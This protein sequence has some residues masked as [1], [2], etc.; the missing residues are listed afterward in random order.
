[1]VEPQVQQRPRCHVDDEHQR[2]VHVMDGHHRKRAE[3]HRHQLD[4]HHRPARREPHGQELVVDVRL[5][6]HEQ[7]LLVARPAHHH[8][9]HVQ[10]RHQQHAE[11]NQYRT[12]LHHQQHIRRVHTIFY[13]EKAQ[14]ESQRQAARVAH[15]NLAPHV[16]ISEHVVRE[17]RD[18]YPHAHERQHG[19][20]PQLQVHEH[21][22]EHHQRHHAQSRSQSVDA[23]NQV[24]RIRDEHHQ[25]HGERNPHLRR[26]QVD[27]EQPVEIVDIQSRKRKHRRRDNLHE[28]FLAVA[29]PHQVVGNAQHVEQRQSPHQEEELTQQRLRPFHRDRPV[30]RDQAHRREDREREQDDR[31]KRHPAQARHRPFVDF[32]FVRFVEQPFA[33]RNNQNVR[34]DDSSQDDR[35]YKSQ[36][37]NI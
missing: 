10:T 36:N 8:P 35:G 28:E 16:R 14:D 13:D 21:H 24:H 37:Q 1:M 11:R 34:N 9:H 3:A 30:A 17:E 5:V 22:A 26:N 20:T 6:G 31:E 2:V 12:A 18:D 4:G 29:H 15:E 33:Q 27:A 7:R 25:Q 19:I 32:P 23:V